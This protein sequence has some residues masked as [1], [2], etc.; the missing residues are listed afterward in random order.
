MKSYEKRDLT[1]TARGIGSVYK[2]TLGF[3]ET[4]IHLGEEHTAFGPC[5]VLF[6]FDLS[7][8]F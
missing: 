7:V 3:R 5:S 8:D 1:E 4:Q 6:C 2:G